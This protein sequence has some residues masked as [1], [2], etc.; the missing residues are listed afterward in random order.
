[1]VSSWQKRR[2]SFNHDWLKN[3]YIRDLGTWMNL[4]DG[5]IESADMERSFTASLLPVWESHRGEALALPKD[6]ETEMSPKV[7]FKELPLLNCDEDTKQW[8]GNLVHHLWFVRYSV[9]QLVSDA[10]E[11]VK[12]TNEAY[13]KLQ[14]ALGDCKDTRKAEALRPL[15]ELFA[16]LLK[17]CRLLAEAVEKFPSEV[18]AV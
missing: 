12:K 14:K 17:N 18:E 2:S 6:F 10:S 16:E 1:M 7:L 8:L 9:N 15:R 4:L 11:S 5:R 13:G 3:E